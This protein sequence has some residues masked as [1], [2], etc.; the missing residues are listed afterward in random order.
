[1]Q[2][3]GVPRFASLIF[4]LV[5]VLALGAV[6]WG[7]SHGKSTGDG[8]GSAKDQAAARTTLQTGLKLPPG[9]TRDPTSTACG[10]VSD[11][12]LTGNTSVAATLETLTT[13]MHA[14]GGSLR[15]ICDATF[16]GSSGTSGGVPTFTCGAQGKLKGAQVVFLLGGGWLLPGHPTPRTAVQVHVVTGTD[17]PKQIPSTGTV[18]DVTYLLPPGWSRASQLCAGGSTAPASSGATPATATGSTSAPPPPSSVVTSPPLPACAPNAITVNVGVHLAL[19]AAATQL[20][21]LALSKGFRL[22]G[23]PCI[24]GATA[25]SCGVWGERITSGVQELF[26]ATLSDNGRGDTTGTLAVTQ[27]R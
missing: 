18:A 1:M 27:L 7:A 13:V 24:S 19:N 14:A 23:R 12:C 22:D 4:C 3:R 15:N 2:R 25:T 5:V 10:N 20:S 16:G 11:V 17:P 9:L 26:V 8:I 6:G 21:D